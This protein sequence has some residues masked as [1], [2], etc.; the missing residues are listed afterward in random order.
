MARAEADWHLRG[1][2]RQVSIAE[3][4]HA[5]TQRKFFHE[6]DFSFNRKN[7]KLIS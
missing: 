7:H 1:S 4:F 6:N 3:E 2:A 5:S